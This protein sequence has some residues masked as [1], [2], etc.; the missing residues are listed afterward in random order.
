MKLTDAADGWKKPLP[1]IQVA[2]NIK[3]FRNM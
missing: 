3:Q 1:P 2:L